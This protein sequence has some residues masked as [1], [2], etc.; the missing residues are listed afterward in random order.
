VN[1]G[2][3][4]GGNRMNILVVDDEIMIAKGLCHII[5]KMDPGLE[6]VDFASSAEEALVKLENTPFD[7]CLVDICMPETS[8]LQLIEQC[9]EKKLCSNFCI[10]SGY[11]EFEYARQGIRLGVQ[12][13]LLKPVDKEMLW[14]MLQS[15]NLSNS[16]IVSRNTV[17]NPYVKKMLNIISNEYI[18]DISLYEVAG[19]LNINTDYAGK[20]FK[21]DTNISFSEYLNRYKLDKVIS[22][23]KVEP[24]SNIEQL[25]IN[26]GFLEIRNFYR[27][28]KKFYNMTPREYREKHL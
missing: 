16:L 1:Q 27:V 12:D 26:N 7:L 13:Y 10:I 24:T 19:K 6:I 14:N 5:R 15:F 22:Q 2:I 21:T 18:H 9:M 28:F 25:A 4:E 3:Q 20:L 11:A 23:M 17:Q 8:G